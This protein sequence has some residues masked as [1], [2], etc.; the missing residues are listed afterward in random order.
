MILRLKH[1]GI[2]RTFRVPG[3]PHLVPIGGALSSAVLM[4]TATAHT[5]IRLFAWMAIG[6]VV[7]CTYSVKHSVLRT[8]KEPAI[9]PPDPR[10]EAP[11]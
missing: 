8:G 6:L 3:G 2:P 4:F 9:P 11:F 1:P 5:I 7:Y 10:S